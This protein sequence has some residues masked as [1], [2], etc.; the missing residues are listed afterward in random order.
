MISWRNSTEWSSCCWPWV[1]NWVVAF[2]HFLLCKSER[3]ENTC[4]L[5]WRPFPAINFC[6][7]EF[8][9]EANTCQKKTKWTGIKKLCFVLRYKRSY[10]P[11]YV[12]ILRRDFF[13][14]PS[15]QLL[16]WNVTRVCFPLM[17]WFHTPGKLNYPWLFLMEEILKWLGIEFAWVLWVPW[18]KASVG[19]LPFIEDSV[20]NRQ[21]PRK[22]QVEHSCLIPPESYDETGSQSWSG[23]PGTARR[24]VG[25]H[26]LKSRDFSLFAW[27]CLMHLG[28]MPYHVLDESHEA[29]THIL[30]IQYVYVYVI[31]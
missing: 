16:P 12:R 30:N 20:P 4:V 18:D 21:H 25:S 22:I 23:F 11:T 15:N 1:G 3:D 27:H 17:K 24:P 26:W 5:Q 2:G 6:I 7:L 9:P 14:I 8:E 10:Y 19:K 13:R 31:Y 28:S 29:Y